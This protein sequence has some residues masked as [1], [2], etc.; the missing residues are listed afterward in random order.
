MGLDEDKLHQLFELQRT[1][2]AR[3]GVKPEEMSSEEKQRWLLQC[4]RA[5]VQETAELTD[6]VPWKWWK[7]S[8]V[9]EKEHAQEE[10]I[11]LLH[12]LL[13]AFMF[14]DMDADAVFEAYCKKNNINH[15]RQ[16]TGY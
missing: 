5:I 9:F 11:D 2:N 12:F 14:L 4:S 16:D 3:I 15:V 7:K 8:M 6:C 1:F 10:A 13:S